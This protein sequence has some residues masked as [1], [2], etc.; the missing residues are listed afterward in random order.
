MLK[1][2][3]FKYAKEIQDHFYN[4]FAN[5]YLVRSAIFIEI[6]EKPTVNI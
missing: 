1:Q 4:T 2:V 5:L 6:D 3:T